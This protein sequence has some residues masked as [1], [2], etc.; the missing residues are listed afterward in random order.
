MTKARAATLL[1]CL[2]S[3]INQVMILMLWW[4]DM[5]PADPVA[6]LSAIL[7][8]L[9]LAAAILQMRTSR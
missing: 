9:A 4:G 2:I 7:L 5:P 8:A 6:F 3:A 1:W